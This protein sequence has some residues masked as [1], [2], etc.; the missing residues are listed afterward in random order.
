MGNKPQLVLDVAGVLIANMSPVFWQQLS[1]DSGISYEKL[2][3]HFKKNVRKSLWTGSITEGDFWNWLGSTFPTV[4]L[5]HARNF[6]ESSLKPLTAMNH[7]ARWS[8]I[9]DIHLLSNHRT[10][11]LRTPLAPIINYI[12][13]ATIS[14]DVGFCKP[15][16]EIYD[17]VAKKLSI[18]QSVFFVD[19]QE[20][21]LRRAIEFGWNTL[22]ADELGLWISHVER[23]LLS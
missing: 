4:N 13:T 12:S 20:K 5:H 17:V 16:R 3:V 9:A 15:H 18:E 22:H 11:W 23:L 1:A 21:N 14:S 2:L 19:D 7:V 6:L 8:E 10:E